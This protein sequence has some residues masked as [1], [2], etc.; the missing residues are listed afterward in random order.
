MFKNRFFML[1]LRPNTK[2]R[3]WIFIEQQV[4][5]FK[6]SYHKMHNNSA[7][8]VLIN[9]LMLNL[10]ISVNSTSFFFNFINKEKNK[11]TF[12]KSNIIHKFL[13]IYFSVVSLK[14]NKKIYS[15][16]QL[17]SIKTF[18]YKKNV[19]ITYQ[20]L[21]TTLKSTVSL[22]FGTMWFEHMTF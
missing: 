8:K 5:K 21:L 2:M 10:Q 7:K 3:N 6:F 18:C 1:A 22:K 16:K 11:K 17:N 14:L 20:F 9:F 15:I 13:Q 12:L 19:F 4:N